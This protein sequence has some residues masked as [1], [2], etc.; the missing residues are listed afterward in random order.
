MTS[1]ATMPPQIAAVHADASAERLFFSQ[2]RLSMAGYCSRDTDYWDWAFEVLLRFVDPE[3]ATILHTKFHIFTRTLKEWAR[4]EIQWRF[5]ACRCLCPD[6]FLVLRLIAA[7]QRNDK[8]TE[9]RAAADLLGRADVE[10]LLAASRS[11]AQELQIREFVL[12]PIERLAIV[13]NPLPVPH[14]YTLQ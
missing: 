3:S 5:S 6:E 11:L 7:S 13:A 9:R 12:A 1:H 10:A 14:S 4:K 2:Y 8:E